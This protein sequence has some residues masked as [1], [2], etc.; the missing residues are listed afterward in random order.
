MTKLSRVFEWCNTFELDSYA[1]LKTKLLYPVNKS[2]MNGSSSVWLALQGGPCVTYWVTGAVH[3]K[4][5]FTYFL[6]SGHII[7]SYCNARCDKITQ[8]FAKYNSAHSLWFFPFSLPP[9][10]VWIVFSFLPDPFGLLRRRL[11]RQMATTTG[12]F[13]YPFWTFVL[14]SFTVQ[15][16][17]TIV[18]FMHYSILF[19]NIS[20]VC[21]IVVTS[22]SA[23]IYS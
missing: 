7:S 18:C 3:F 23:K 2:A 16:T 17:I 13:M 4:P 19:G 6:F 22:S 8:A 11:T 10:P 1:F 9:I 12:N 5:F 15:N 14:I 20:N 21:V